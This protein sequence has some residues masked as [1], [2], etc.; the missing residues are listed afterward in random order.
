MKILDSTNKN[1]YKVLENLLSLRKNKIKSSSI[2][3]TNI[4]K[5]VKKNGDKALLRY[6]KRF[7]QNKIIV[8]TSKQISKSIKSLDIK[9]KKAID[10]AYDR[11]YKFHSLQKFKNISYTDKLK[12]KFEDKY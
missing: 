6:E 3:I 2:S 11:I 12:N 9:V 8:P 1:F 10:L 7:N 5:D 4:I